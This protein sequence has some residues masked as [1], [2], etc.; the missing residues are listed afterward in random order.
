MPVRS[1]RVVVAAG[2]GLVLLFASCDKSPTSPRP[3]QQVTTVR[4]ELVAPPEIAPDETV[5]LTA[6][7]SKSDG[8]VENVSSQAQWTSATS[9]VLQLGSTGLATGRNRGEVFVTVRFGG[10]S[11]TAP[12]MVLPKGTFRLSGTV[13]EGGFVKL[14]NVTV[15]VTS[16]VGE[17]LTA[18]T[19]VNGGFV[20]YGVSG[21]VKL[22]ARREGYTDV[23]TQVPGPVTAHRNNSDL[24]MVSN[25]PLVDLSG[26]YTLTISSQ[27]A[28]PAAFPDAARR[29]SYTA[30]V[31]QNKDNCCA[32]GLSVVLT[33]ADFIVHN[34]RYWN[35]FH[36]RVTSTGEARLHITTEDFD[37]N[38]F[39]IAERFGDTAI[40][41]RGD[42]SAKATPELISGTLAGEILIAQGASPPFES[43]SSRCPAALFEMVRR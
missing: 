1:R 30:N 18:V 31:K 4:L 42:V 22:H 33:G 43:Y 12:I 21:L 19:N 10:L 34:G 16:S 17:G 3:P 32:G 23:V 14:E 8:S 11:A 15:T 36:G 27:S 39:Y 29:R 20:L 9:E 41:V 13:Y 28:C 35:T 7:A 37:G 25:R 5:Q 38:Q 40:L 6:N 24:S 2:A 26:T